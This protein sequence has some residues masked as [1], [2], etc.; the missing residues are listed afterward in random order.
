MC[1]YLVLKAVVGSVPCSATKIQVDSP[2]FGVGFLLS[3][4]VSGRT[5]CKRL[6]HT[7][8]SVLK[9]SRVPSN[10]APRAAA[11]HVTPLCSRVA[12]TAEKNLNSVIFFVSEIR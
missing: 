7:A 12:D 1:Y 8:L 4:T 5:N 9:G 3:G 6:R 2:F 10:I 11:L